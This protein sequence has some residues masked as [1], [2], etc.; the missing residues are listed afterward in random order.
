MFDS[1]I[2]HDTPAK[3]MTRQGNAGQIFARVCD[4]MG[5]VRATDIAETRL[6]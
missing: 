2:D 1:C 4:L 6:T 3:C 5:K